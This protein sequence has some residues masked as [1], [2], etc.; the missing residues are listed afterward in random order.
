MWRERPVVNDVSN[1][2]AKIQKKRMCWRQTFSG[3]ANYTF[4]PKSKLWQYDWQWKMEIISYRELK[5]TMFQ[6]CKNSA[7]LT[8]YYSESV[9]DDQYI[10][11]GKF[12]LWYKKQ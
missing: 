10:S 2:N 8:C 12:R 1:E 6:K 4:E 9:Y 5:T 7:S 11:R 3:D